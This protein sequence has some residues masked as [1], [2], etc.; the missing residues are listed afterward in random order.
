MSME[1]NVGQVGAA[2]EAGRELDALVAERVMGWTFHPERN[3]PFQ[4]EHHDP[5]FTPYALGPR[6]YSTEIGAAWEVVERMADEGYEL[7]LK[8]GTA[9]VHAVFSFIDGDGHEHIMGEDDGWNPSAVPL[10]IC[11]AA[12]VART[13]GPLAAPPEE[14]RSPHTEDER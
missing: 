5:R 13:P 4:W 9:E 2:L 12:L 1:T 6:L 10:H 7:D 11:R 14:C 8:V 3:E